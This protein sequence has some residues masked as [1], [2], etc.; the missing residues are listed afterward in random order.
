MGIEEAVNVTGIRFSSTDVFLQP[1]PD[2][3][4]SDGQFFAMTSAYSNGKNGLCRSQSSSAF[5]EV[6]HW[7]A[8]FYTAVNP[9]GTLRQ[10]PSAH[11]DLSR[12]MTVPPQVS[13]I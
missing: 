1:L 10:V 8:T 3:I 9:P 13:S 11:A 6:I 12:S 4:D 2:R 5:T 7:K